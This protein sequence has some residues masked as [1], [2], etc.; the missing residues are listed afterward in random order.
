MSAG[1][2]ATTLC[3][4]IPLTGTT[5]V[6][7]DGGVSSRICRMRWRNQILHRVAIK[8]LLVDLHTAMGD[9]AGITRKKKISTGESPPPD[10]MDSSDE[11]S[12]FMLAP[13]SFAPYCPDSP[14]SIKHALNR[15]PKSTHN[16]PHPAATRFI[17]RRH[18]ESAA[19][20]VAIALTSAIRPIT[21][22]AHVAD[23]I[24][25]H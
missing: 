5:S 14:F 19:D 1:H 17:S 13:S 9:V 16:F 24:S 3:G 18:V 22:T 10:D 20:P 4:S 11:A 12:N 21:R 8:T 23:S 15:L 2:P 25:S 6:V 7:G